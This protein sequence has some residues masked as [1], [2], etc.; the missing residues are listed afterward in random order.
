[1]TAT[2]TKKVDMNEF[3]SHR[4][5]VQD[6]VEKNILKDPKIAPDVQQQR[7]ELSKK[8]I[9]D[10]L[11]H[12]IENGRTPEVLVEHNI[13]KNTHVSPLLQQS[14]LKLEKHQL[15][16]KLEHKLEKRPVPEDLVKQGIL[17]ADEV[18]R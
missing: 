5:E 8:Q 6:L 3:L 2:E 1:M 7:V 17:S 15:H 12:K 14:Q 13:L 4:P 18:P 16:D 11:R 9:E 10:A